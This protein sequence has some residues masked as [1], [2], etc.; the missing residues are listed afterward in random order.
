V[1]SQQGPAV[2]CYYMRHTKAFDFYKVYPPLLHKLEL[3]LAECDSRGTEY[4][5]TSGWRSW[6]EQ[7]RLYALGRTV[8]NVDASEERPL[9]GKV[10]NARGGQSFHNMGLAVD[11]A[12]DKD[13]Q[14]D[15]LQPEWDLQKFRTLA[16]A[17]RKHGLEAGFWW[18]NFKDGPHVEL[19]IK[20]YGLTLAQL[21]RLH[22]QGGLSG[23]WSFLD[24]YQW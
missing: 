17:A 10:T 23:V 22:E 12:P 7:N 11:F 16:E 2:I 3:V 14:R 13:T 4:W 21:A 20:K 18:V 6:E 15:G 24:K 1:R 19:P 8:K 5:A 9:G